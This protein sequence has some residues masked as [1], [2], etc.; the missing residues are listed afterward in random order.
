MTRRNCSRTPPARRWAET[1]F[2]CCA[3]ALLP[4][5]LASSGA[6]AGQSGAEFLAL[7]DQADAWSDGYCAGYVAGA[8]EMLDGLLLDDEVRAAFDG[9]IFCL[10]KDVTKGEVRDRVVGFLREHPDVAGSEMTS[11]TW[12]V[13]IEAYPCE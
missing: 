6:R 2:S 4:W 3:L 8:G 9:R 7:C 1:L 10:P 12:A 11:I 5:L 13:L